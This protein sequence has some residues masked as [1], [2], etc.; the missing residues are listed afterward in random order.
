M[1]TTKLVGDAAGF[2]SSLGIGG[3]IAIE[4]TGGYAAARISRLQVVARDGLGLL[5][6]EATWREGADTNEQCPCEKQEATPILVLQDIDS[7]DHQGDAR[8]D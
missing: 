6:G 2:N 7:R 4:A 8:E 1:N 3:T 5:G